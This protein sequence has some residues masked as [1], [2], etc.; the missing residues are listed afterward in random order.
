MGT[1]PDLPHGFLEELNALMYTQLPSQYL[2]HNNHSVSISCVI[3]L[4]GWSSPPCITVAP[5]SNPVTL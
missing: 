1:L 5:Y 2:A 3:F 4:M